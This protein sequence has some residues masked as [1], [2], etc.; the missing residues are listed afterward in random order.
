MP[1]KNRSRGPIGLV[2]CESGKPFAEK[3]MR[4]LSEIVAQEK[5][6][7]RRHKKTELEQV[8]T[9]ET[10]FPNSEVKTTIDDSIRGMDIYIIQDCE[11]KVGVKSVDKQLRALYTAIDAVRRA[12]AKCIT[13]VIPYYPYSRQD[14]AEGREPITAA[15]VAREIEDAGAKHVI[16]LDIHNQAIGGFFRKLRSFENLHASK[17]LIPHLEQTVGT[18]NLVIVA[19]DAGGTKRAEFYAKHM[20]TSLAIIHKARD[21]KTGEV[22]HMVFLGDVKG[23]KA[24]LVDD[25]IATAGTLQRSVKLLRD[26]GA[27]YVGFACCLSLFTPPALDRIQEAVSAGYLDQVIGTDAIYH[28]GQAFLDAHPWYREVSVAPYFAQVVYNMNHNMSISNLLT[29]NR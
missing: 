18:D 13:A 5:K 28:G 10:V 1:S 26:N 21:Y 20:R 23:K 17:A 25:M 7:S 3:I 8:H 19:P 24:L 15:M 6:E 2:A 27:T 29:F 16:T 12:D 4:S 22:D 11:N 9:R 14:R